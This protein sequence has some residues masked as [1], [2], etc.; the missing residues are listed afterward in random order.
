MKLLS[1]IIGCCISV[2]VTAQISVRG[3]ISDKTG[4]TLPLAHVIVLPD[5]VIAEADVDGNFSVSIKPGYKQFQVS[6]TGYQ[7]MEISFLLKRDTTLAFPLEQ[8]IDQLKEVVVRSNR[9]AQANWIETTR[10]GTTTI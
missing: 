7:S 4:E 9:F 6:F 10:T 8:K 3:V 1:C 2:A 5:S